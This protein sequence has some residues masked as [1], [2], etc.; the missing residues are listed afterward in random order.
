MNS[1]TR[2]QGNE[3]DMTPSSLSRNNVLPNGNNLSQQVSITRGS[4]ISASI[5]NGQFRRQL[6]LVN[7][8]GRKEL[9]YTVDA[10]PQGT[11]ERELSLLM[12]DDFY[13]QY[14]RWTGTRAPE[15][16]EAEWDVHRHPHLLG[17]L[18]FNVFVAIVG[19]VLVCV[20]RL[21]GRMSII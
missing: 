18:L 8:D 17:N 1:I 21:M 4:S 15:H 13:H 9:I 16:P 2:T 3:R 20:C 6:H 5:E 11:G 7:D 14:P 19:L 10:R 12:Q